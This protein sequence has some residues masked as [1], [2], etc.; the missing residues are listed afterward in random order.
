MAAVG[1]RRPKPRSWTVK[2]E[3]TGGD[4]GRKKAVVQRVAGTESCFRGA[5]TPL[6]AEIAAL[7]AESESAAFY[8]AG[9]ERI[10]QV[11]GRIEDAGQEL[12]AVLARWMELEERRS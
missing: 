12:E 9:A 2:K 4:S 5:S 7:R 3:P 11:L 8:Q 1:R 10:R 6:E